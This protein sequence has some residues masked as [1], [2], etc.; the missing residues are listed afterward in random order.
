MA[1]A[2]FCIKKLVDDRFY[3]FEG[4]DPRE[5]SFSCH[6][7]LCAFGV[8]MCCGW[9]FPSSQATK[10]SVTSFNFSVLVLGASPRSMANL[11][12]TK[13]FRWWTQNV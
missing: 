10:K 9:S 8:G 7:C 3:F 11:K 2:M 4:I 13:L 6:P 12:D 5:V 1:K